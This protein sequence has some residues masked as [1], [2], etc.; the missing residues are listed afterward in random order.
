VT[1]PAKVEG[2]YVDVVLNASAGQDEEGNFPRWLLQ[3][4]QKL[5][6]QHKITLALQR[7]EEWYKHWDGQVYVA[8]SGGKDSTVLLDLVRSLYPEV[9]AVFMNTG[10][11]F[12]EIVQFVKT[13]ENVVTVR[14]KMTFKQ[15]IEKYGY[16]L[17]GKEQAQ[18]I[19]EARTT[20]SEA[21]WHKRV[22]G[23][24]KDGSFTKFH[25]SKC[26]LRLIEAPF[27]VSK[28][29]CTYLKMEPVKRYVKDT[30][31]QGFVGVLAQDS[32]LR[33]SAW[34]RYGC[35]IYEGTGA[36]SMPL[37]CW[38]ED[39]IWDY[40]KTY[41]IPYSS[42]YDMGYKRTGCIFCMFGVHLEK[43]ENRFQLLKKT[44][45]KL[46]KYCM[47]NLGIREVLEFINVPCE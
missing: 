3:E 27:K 26:H 34:Q 15:V 44:H 29:C 28:K 40:L 11:E 5:P 30:G 20:K 35:N 13:I 4:R 6:L 24:N 31:R 39:D 41:D 19:E 17:P 8:F 18:W 46:W 10:L 2:S 36:R 7:I 14:P 42:I 16:P 47:D 32:I 38:M 33:R 23:I 1:L 22:N 9:P 45:P 43:G 21:L 37:S 25:I 12:P